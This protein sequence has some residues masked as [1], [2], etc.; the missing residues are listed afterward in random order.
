[1]NINIIAIG[2]FNNSP[3][4]EIY[5]EYVK[6][7]KWKIELRELELKN[8]ASLSVAEVKAGEGDLLLKALKPS[9]KLIALDENGRQF[10]SREF[11]DKI[12][13]FG[14]SGQSDLTFVIGGA[15]GLSPEVLQRAELKISLGK[16]T[17]PHLL[18]RAVLAEQ[19][20]R[21]QTIIAGHP[22]HK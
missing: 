1:M 21:A 7:L 6:R 14:N 10:S 13:D 2:K 22:Y 12:K 3:E 17:L 9:S 4:K 16:M 15:N 11:A 18:V 20:Y 8:S 5:L 19:I